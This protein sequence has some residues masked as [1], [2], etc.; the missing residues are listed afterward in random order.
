VRQSSYADQAIEYGLSDR[1]EL[2]AIADA[3][4][5]WAAKP[6]AI[7]IALCVEVIARNPC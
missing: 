3:W 7:F 4:R 2:D 5:R 1:K 6:D